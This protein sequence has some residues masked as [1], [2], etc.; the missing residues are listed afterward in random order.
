MATNKS[1]LKFIWRGKKSSIANSIL[2][3][4]NKVGELTLSSFQT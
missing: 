1:I 4:R 2:K 3:E